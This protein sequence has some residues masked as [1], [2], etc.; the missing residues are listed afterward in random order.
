MADTEE[1]NI[2]ALSRAVLRDAHSDADQVL[3]EAREK[4]E[5]ILQQAREQSASVRAEILEAARREA[6]R[7]QSE[8]VSTA[9]LKARMLQLEQREKLLDEAF[10]T[11]RQQLSLLQQGSDYGQIARRLLQ[12]ALAQ[13]GVKELRLRMDPLT[14]KM[15]TDEVLAQAAREAGVQVQPGPA[16]ERGL[17]VIAETLDGHRQFDNTLEA[18]LLRLQD[19]L[20]MPVYHLLK[21]ERL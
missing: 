10:S 7:I 8:Q 1:P 20:R 21:G 15:L 5:A 12:E 6:Q 16:L 9:Q 3:A 13:L 11:A 17:G 4:S 2:E 19:S 18:R 14:R